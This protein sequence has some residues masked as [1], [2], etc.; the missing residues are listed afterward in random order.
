MLQRTVRTRQ[1][2]R[3]QMYGQLGSF[4]CVVPGK[5]NTHTVRSGQAAGA[6]A[7]EGARRMA[8]VP[9]LL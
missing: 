4:T 5:E 3:L 1:T 9:F 7:A 8:A 2:T 6:S